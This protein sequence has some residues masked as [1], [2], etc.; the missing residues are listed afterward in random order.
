MFSKVFLVCALALAAS[1]AS[2][3]Q[4]QQQQQQ[5]RVPGG[6][7]PFEAFIL[8]K[9]AVSKL[10]LQNLKKVKHLFQ[11]YIFFLLEMSIL[12]MKTT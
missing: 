8:I 7:Y 4:Q 9:N 10:Q 6:E 1:A 3:P 5:E 2:I 12:Q 11:I